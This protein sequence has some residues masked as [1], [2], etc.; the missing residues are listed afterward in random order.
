MA[1]H[2]RRDP[3]RGPVELSC[4][5]MVPVGVT[6]GEDPATLRVLDGAPDGYDSAYYWLG[7]EPVG[8]VMTTEELDAV[9]AE[10]FLGPD[11]H[12]VMPYY[13]VAAS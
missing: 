6:P 8:R 13:R 11:R 12:G 1:R 5:V 10:R 2:T 4:W 3:A 9:A 7:P